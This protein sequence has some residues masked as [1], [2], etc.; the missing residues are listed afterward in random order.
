MK[1]LKSRHRLLNSPTQPGP[2]TSI[3]EKQPLSAR[4]PMTRGRAR[5]SDAKTRSRLSL[6]RERH[7]VFTQAWLAA[8]RPQHSSAREAEFVEAREATKN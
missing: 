7:A 5:Q 4:E 1:K 6:D 2:S 8:D 3:M